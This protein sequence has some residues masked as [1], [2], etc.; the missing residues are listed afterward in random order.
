MKK[1]AFALLLLPNAAFATD[2]QILADC[3]IALRS[4]FT[5]CMKTKNADA[6]NRRCSTAICFG[7]SGHEQTFTEFLSWRKN[8]GRILA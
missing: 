5:E 6:C 3:E 7:T 2:K 8:K 4:C 1:I